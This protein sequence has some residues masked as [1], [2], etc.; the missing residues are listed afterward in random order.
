TNLPCALQGARQAAEHLKQ[1]LGIEFNE[2]TPDGRVT[3]KEGE[4]FGAC[5]DAPV[6]LVNNKKMEGFM[7]P[8]ALDRLLDEL[9]AAAD[10][11]EGPSRAASSASGGSAAAK[12]Q[13][14]GDHNRGEGAQRQ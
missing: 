6:L 7:N 10:R 12:P 14:W 2:T 1:K 9:S 8:P 11:G 13:A 5:G 3:L 4:C